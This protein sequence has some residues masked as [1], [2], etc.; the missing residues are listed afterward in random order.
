MLFINMTLH[1]LLGFS[2]YN[3]NVLPCKKNADFGKT[4][5]TSDTKDFS[6]EVGKTH[7][8]VIAVS[9]VVSYSNTNL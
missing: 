2:P 1:Q 4:K 3:Y 8:A 6:T 7:S 5:Y 9:N